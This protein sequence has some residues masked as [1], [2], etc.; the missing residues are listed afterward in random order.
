M[1]HYVF[2][3]PETIQEAS[4]AGEMGLG[5]LIELLNGF[6]RDVI[7]A[8][9]DAWRVES[10]LKEMV[11]AIPF[12]TERKMLMDILISLKL[13][14]P[15]LVIEGDVDLEMSLVAFARCQGS[16][17]DLDL[18]LSPGTLENPSDE[19]WIKASL[20]NLHGSSFANRRRFLE[21]GRTFPQGNSLFE[22]IAAQ[23]FSKLVRH[24]DTVRIFDYALGKYY[25]NDQ[26]TN[27]KRLVRFLR[28]HARQLK[29]LHL[30]TLSAASK[31]LKRDI[32]DLQNEVDFEIKLELKEHESEL[33]HPRYLGADKRYLDIDRGID[34]CDAHDRNRLTQIKYASCPVV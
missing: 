18:I 1:F 27:L 21:N 23:C 11:L 10:E 17:F 7:L 6:R 26:P 33:P 22:Q 4:D 9:T 20:T 32:A 8:E 14:G 3:D 2:L 29:A 34:L 16:K 12:Q 28:D 24:A 25:G 19:T 31:S 13:S 15:Q 30:C 5:R